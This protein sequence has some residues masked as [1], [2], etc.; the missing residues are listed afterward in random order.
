MR[1]RLCLL[2]V[3]AALPC[4]AQFSTSLQP[5]TVTE[6]QAYAQ[7]VESQLQERWSGK[8][9]FLSLD[10]H[11]A[12]LASVMHGQLWIAPGNSNNPVPVYDGLIHDWV[13]AVFIPKADLAKVLDVLQNFDRHQQIYPEVKRS[14]LISRQGDEI[15]GYWRIERKQALAVVLDVTQTVRWQQIAPGKWVARAYTNDIREVENPG[16]PNERDLPPGQGNG[17]LW[18]L[19]AY[20]SLEATGFG[21]LGECRSLSLSRSIPGALSWIIKP[22]IQSLPRDTLTNT[23]EHTRAAVNSASAR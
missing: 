1:L 21:V 15:T 7:R 6:F 3:V 8:K 16:S 20:W 14:K 13:G 17:F 19:Y 9:S 11:P 4:A 10:D 5:R 18:R 22:F 12:E 2:L 23:L